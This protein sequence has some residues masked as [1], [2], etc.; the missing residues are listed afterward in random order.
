MSQIL[1][2]VLITSYKE[3]ETI[4]K[5]VHAVINQQ[6]STLSPS[7]I[8]IIVVA[9]D[10]ETL[11][12][13]REAFES[14]TKQENQLPQSKDHDILL[15]RENTHSDPSTKVGGISLDNKSGKPNF[16]TIKDLGQ[17]KP[18]AL[19]LAVPQALGEILLLTDGDMYIGKSSLEEIWGHFAN[20]RVFGV[21]GHP[22]SNDSRNNQFGYYSHL[23]CEAAHQ[24]RLIDPRTPMSGY[25]Y[26][27][28]NPFLYKQK[29]SWEKAMDV[30]N[31]SH[32][33]TIMDIFPIPKE[34]R[35][36]DAY[37]STKIQESG[38]KTDYEPKALAYVKFPKNLDDWIKQKTRSLG[39]NVQVKHKR[40]IFED[41][42]MALFPIKF[43]KTPKELTW[44]LSLYP[45][46]L[47]LW[48]KIYLNHFTHNYKPGR[49]ER[50]E[51]S[52]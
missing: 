47:Y 51:S 35:A 12:S 18:V 46:R 6:Y 10:D 31:M 39:G 44:S 2:S 3:P 21:S 30:K 52:K 41:L 50:I 40:N 36:E 11:I 49:W 14:S 1:I 43:A 22:V 9:P 38:Y 4:K 5:A 26:A 33:K 20:P 42:G 8:E 16:L 23:F 48:L 7:Q 27:F 13:A 32:E 19:N 45:I 15:S 28:R 24:K 17:G 29:M 25:L 37:I 34:I